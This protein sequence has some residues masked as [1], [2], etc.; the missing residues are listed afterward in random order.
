MII[1]DF[2]WRLDLYLFILFLSIYQ[3]FFCLT[4]KIYHFCRR[5]ILDKPYL[6]QVNIA[7]IDPPIKCIV[8]FICPA[9]LARF[10]RELLSLTGRFVDAGGRRLFRIPVE[11]CQGLR[12]V[13]L[14][15]EICNRGIAPHL[16]SRVIPRIF[17][18]D[19]QKGWLRI[20]LPIQFPEIFPT[21]N[22]F[23]VNLLLHE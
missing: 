6:F 10:R 9:A 20:F 17:P 7:I 21:R 16:V 2:F 3:K 12:T 15:G 19:V 13:P 11:R 23:L 18:F 22:N 8:G 1:F 14:R 5:A 4:C